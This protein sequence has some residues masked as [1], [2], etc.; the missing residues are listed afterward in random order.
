MMTTHTLLGLV[1]G[2][3]CGGTGSS[4]PGL[5][6]NPSPVA[7]SDTAR[8]PLNELGT[9]T[10]RG[11]QG[12][13]YP[14]GNNSAP[15]AHAAVG[16]AQA[17]NIRRLD[18]G[19]NPSVN[20]KYVLLAIGMS[21][22]TQEF[23]GG[24]NS[25]NCLPETFM[26]RAAGD[27]EVNKAGL[28][29]VDGAQGGRDAK[30]WTSPS[31]LTFDVVRDERLARLGVTESQ[32]QVVWLKSADAQPRSALP[33]SDA[34][35]Y[36][37][38]ERLASSVRALKAR[39][40]NLQQVFLTSRIYAGYASSTLNPEPYAYESGFAVKWLVQ[41]QIDQAQRG[42]VVD[43]RAGDLNYGAVAPWIAWGPY[44]WAD[45]IVTRSDGLQWLQSDFGGDGTHPSEAGRAKVG[46]MLLSFF[47]NS[48]YTRCW[49]VTGG[50]C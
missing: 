43:E 13:L 7:G 21:N 31:M 17:K 40:P 26:G 32:V 4:A 38:E 36:I 2:I 50:S 27:P 35:A 49:F 9:R 23:C 34:D 3:A 33:A 25:S 46:A 8:V 48:S 14:G 24:N 6:G 10:Y 16:L 20:G 22:T 37:L 19:G 12:G 29:I 18:A 28:V 11:F 5:D 1:A 47:K 45:G 30:E 39:Y 15:S 42:I 41:A 44:P